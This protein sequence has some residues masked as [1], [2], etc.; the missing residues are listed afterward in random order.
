MVWCGGVY[1]EEELVTRKK[2]LF[3]VGGMKWRHSLVLRRL[4]A[5]GRAS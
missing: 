2:I 5:D 3:V 4:L 1:E